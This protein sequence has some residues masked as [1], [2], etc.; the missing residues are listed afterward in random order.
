MDTTTETVKARIDN[1]ERAWKY[2]E[3]ITACEKQIREA[4][5]KI[6]QLKRDMVLDENKLSW[7]NEGVYLAYQPSSEACTTHYIKVKSTNFS[8]VL[9]DE[10]SGDSKS[11]QSEREAQLKIIGVGFTVFRTKAC[12]TTVIEY[13]RRTAYVPIKD[14]PRLRQITQEEWCQRIEGI[15]KKMDIILLGDC[16]G[17]RV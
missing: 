7:L 4:E 17:E 8:S 3:Q 15:K 16:N 12:D 10:E 1:A 5:S 11:D 13:N 9:A 14:I 2:E 6:R